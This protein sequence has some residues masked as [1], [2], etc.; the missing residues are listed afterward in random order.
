MLENSETY[1]VVGQSCEEVQRGLGQGM[2]PWK[3][4]E[5][6]IRRS[7]QGKRRWASV[8]TG[9]RKGREAGAQGRGPTSPV[10]PQR[11]R[12]WGTLVTTPIIRD[13]R[14]RPAPG[15]AKCK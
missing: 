4:S 10:P 5:S 15:G 3:M 11:L 13:A 6:W 12:K 9:D 7:E 8:V 14:G 2:K 1:Q